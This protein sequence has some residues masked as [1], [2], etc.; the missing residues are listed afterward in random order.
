L[1]GYDYIYGMKKP[2][3]IIVDDHKL[4]RSG[5]KF[6]LEE[7]GLYQVMA[8]ASNGAE[9]LD[10]LKNTAPDL[11]I[12]DINMPVMNGIEAAKKA[13]ILY[14]A[15]PILILSMHSESDYYTTLLETGVKGFVLKDADNDEF[16]TAIQKVLHGGTYFSQELLLNIIKKES[17]TNTV[18]LTRREKEVL[19]LLSKGHS[20]QEISVFLNISQRTVERHRTILLEKTGSRNSVSLI[21]YAI[22]NKLI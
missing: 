12:L 1:L 22:K 15:L 3:I 7:S 6:I 19:E 14:P 2:G 18:K 20:N 9:F 13:I 8:E 4:F 16:F 10:L 11:V 5:L 21:V 17:Q